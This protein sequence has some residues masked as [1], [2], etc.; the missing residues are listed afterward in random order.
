MHDVSARGWTVPGEVA[1]FGE[2]AVPVTEAGPATVRVE[3]RAAPWAHDVSAR[4]R[5][6]SA[7][8]DDATAVPTSASCERGGLT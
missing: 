3:F 6:V 5:V 4:E 7:G 2:S 8:A 1:A